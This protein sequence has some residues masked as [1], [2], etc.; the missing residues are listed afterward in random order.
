MASQRLAVR[1]SQRARWI[2]RLTTTMGVLTLLPGIASLFHHPIPWP[3]FLFILVSGY[4]FSMPMLARRAALKYFAKKPDRDMEVTWEISEKGVRSRT[5]LAASENTWSF[6]P[7]VIRAR[8][9]FL[10]YPSNHIF[11]WLP[12]HAFRNAEDAERFAQIAKSK[13][14]DYTEVG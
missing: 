12:M 9:G 6:F 5:P 3:G 13:V 10:L 8:E 14:R 7:K 4:L 11:H 2:Y 1:Y